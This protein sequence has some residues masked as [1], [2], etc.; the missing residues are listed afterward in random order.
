[1]DAERMNEEQDAA[2]VS[3]GTLMLLLRMKIDENIPPI[4]NPIPWI[5]ESLLLSVGTP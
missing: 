1:M 4:S 2:Q 5:I 3:C